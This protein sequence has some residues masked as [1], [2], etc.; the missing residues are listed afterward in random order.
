M[1][2][3][4]YLFVA[5]ALAAPLAGG[6][7]SVDSFWNRVV[8]ANQTQQ[9]TPEQFESAQA[10]PQG[11]AVEQSGGL[12]VDNPR[13]A[14]SFQP[15][16]QLP[17][18]PARQTP[19]NQET[20]INSVVASTIGPSTTTVQATTQPTA[21]EAP[22]QTAPPPTPSTTPTPATMPTTTVPPSSVLSE[23]LTSAQPEPASPAPASE[24]SVASGEYL[25]LGGVVAEVNG[26]PIY[27]NKVLRMVEP[28]L[29]NDA[30]QMQ[31]DQ[32]V[33]SARAHIVDAIEVLERDE[34]QY[35]AAADS[36]DTSD[37]K[38]VNDLT[39]A[40]RQTLITQAG[41]SVE[42]ARRKAAADGDDFDEL[43][44]DQ[45]RKY[46]I[47][48]YWQK[49]YFPLTEPSAEEMREYYQAHIADYSEPSEADF[50]MLQIDP[51]LLGADTPNQDRQLA[52][53]RAKQAHDRSVAGDNFATLF[54]EFNNDPDL[55]ARTNG[56]GNMGV[57]QRGSFFNTQIEDAVWR[58]VPGQTTDVMEING[59]LYIARLDSRKIG[60]VHPF[61]DEDVQ[62][63]IRQTIESQRLSQ[64]Q[65]QKIDSLRQEAIITQHDEM[66]DTAV[67]MAMANYHAW[68]G[69]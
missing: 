32:F 2:A 17:P 44:H 58:L 33:E 49:N 52:F 35:A 41:G 7:A 38:E 4:R 30:S 36:L 31:P 1:K 5:W 8:G 29:K 16:E 22:T 51:A 62:K 12:G 63:Q 28:G 42:M 54:K 10:A 59:N 68:N 57:F 18:E 69:K 13:L 65:N 34:L 25:P 6:C 39:T 64:L 21:V 27:I 11:Q 55:A 19:I 47:L 40:Y 66:V 43:I 45:Y 20:G 9:V 50:D 61:E 26:T 37:K 3:S 46:M 24:P 14:S 48:L 60:I 67:D 53:S 15:V 56:T 23:P